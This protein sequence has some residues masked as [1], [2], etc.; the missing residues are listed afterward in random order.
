MF[1]SSAMPFC[2]IGSIIR[3][4]AAFCGTLAAAAV[5]HLRTA[6]RLT[7]PVLTTAAD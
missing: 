4:P 5:T 6:S 7:R 3:S 2:T 1:I